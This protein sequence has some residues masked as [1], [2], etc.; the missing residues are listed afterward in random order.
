MSPSADP[1]VLSRAEL[2]ALVVR[3]LGE[4]AE[5]KQVVAAKREEIAR[6]KGLKG[7]P[8][9]KPSGMEKGTEAK[10]GGKRPKR[11]G[12]GKV[13]PRVAVQTEV[14]RV[15][16][17]PAQRR[18][19]LPMSPER[20]VTHVSGRTSR[21]QSVMTGGRA[22]GPSRFR[23]GQHLVNTGCLVADGFGLMPYPSPARAAFRLI[24]RARG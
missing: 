6:L 19:V 11:R 5:L 8:S 13:A 15:R 1:S 3:L 24:E 17:P 18:K 20:D 10:P 22:S 2:E 16:A 21:F 9:I 4:V 23:L 14:L 7:R 12:R